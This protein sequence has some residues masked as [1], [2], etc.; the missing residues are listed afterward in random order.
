[1][2]SGSLR[3]LREVFAEPA[4]G[5]HVDLGLHEVEVGG[6]L[7]DRVLDLQ[8]GVDLEEGEQPLPW[9]VE[10]LHGAR[11]AVLHGQCEPLGG[12]LQLAGLLGG[13]HG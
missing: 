2:A 5:G 8:P 4:A 12:R 3:K 1:M 10:E 11:A 9:V 6:G 13:E 7:G